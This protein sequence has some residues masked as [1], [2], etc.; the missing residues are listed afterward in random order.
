MASTDDVRVGV[1]GVGY[2]G[3]NHARILSSLP[4]AEL[5]GVFDRDAEAAGEVASERGAR[6]FDSP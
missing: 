2:M 3:R 6:R 5:V 4:G 1:F